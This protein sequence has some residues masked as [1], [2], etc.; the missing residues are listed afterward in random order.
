M[1]YVINVIEFK[2]VVIKLTLPAAVA[3]QDGK[4]R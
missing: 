1:K 2:I 3:L 4:K